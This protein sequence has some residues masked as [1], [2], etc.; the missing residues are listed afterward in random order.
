MRPQTCWADLAGRAVGIYGLG[1][2]GHANLRAAEAVG[3]DPIVIVDD[4]PSEA[5]RAGA[6]PRTGGR[7]VLATDGGG[8]PALARC[9]YVIKSPGISPYQP[10]LT[11][12]KAAGGH[13]VTVVSGLGMWLAAAPLDRVLVITGT[14]GKSTTT[15][16]AGHLLTQ[17]GYRTFVGGNLGDPPQDP[18]V[19]GTYDY[20]VIEV[21]SYQAVNLPVTPPVAALT[22]LDQDHLIWHGSVAQYYDD[23][24]SALAQPGRRVTVANGDSDLIRS[25][26]AALAPT[27]RWV[28]ADDDPADT[29]PADLNL[30]GR[31][32]RRNALIAKVCLQELGVQ[33]AHDRAALTEAARDFTPLMSRLERVR[34]IGG[35]DFV[36]DGLS[37]NVLPTVA[38]VGAFPDRKVALLVGGQS[39]GIDYRPLAG[40]LLDR[41]LPVRIFSMPTN[42]PEILRA[43][44]AADLG[45][46]IT[47]TNT[48]DLHAAVAAAYR[49]AQ[50]DGVVLLSPAAPSFDLFENY[51]HRRAAF[52]EAIDQLAD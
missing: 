6:D 35:V 38:A 51:Q 16:I 31:H 5:M 42:G 52:I 22:S 36:E 15:S 14:K 10:W 18:L 3:A 9:D 13:Q 27:V 48:P 20:W 39:R 34:T 11:Y 46:R 30:P 1:T 40:G 4:A 2:E 45:P 8:L 23:K 32:N 50:P 37:T 19:T 17:F 33:E 26:A 28:R 43:V 24:L 21:S 47:G 12:L 7:P 49:W 25:R 41:T 44:V 29:W